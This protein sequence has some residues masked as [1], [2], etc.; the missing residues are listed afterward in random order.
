VPAMMAVPTV[1]SAVMAVSTMIMMAVM[2]MSVPEIEVRVI[3]IGISVAITV[4]VRITKTDGNAATDDAFRLTVF[5]IPLDR[6]VF[7]FNA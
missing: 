3:A 5:E 1:V 4:A 7:D 2:M 6:Q